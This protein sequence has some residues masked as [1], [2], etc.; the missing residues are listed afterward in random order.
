MT[1]GGRQRE[2]ALVRPWEA[3]GLS[4]L[5]RPPWGA[6]HIVNK[7]TVLSSTVPTLSR[8]LTAFVSGKFLIRVNTE[9]YRLIM[10]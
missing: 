10:V 8:V 4:Q 2:S 6:R 1:A 9:K 5:T 3:M 7:W